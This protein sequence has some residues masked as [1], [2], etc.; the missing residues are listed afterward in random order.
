MSTVPSP[1]EEDR[2]GGIN[3]Q[4]GTGSLRAC[5]TTGAPLPTNCATPEHW[6]SVTALVPVSCFDKWPQMHGVSSVL[7]QLWL[8]GGSCCNMASVAVLRSRC[9]HGL[10]L[11]GG[12]LGQSISLPSHLLR[13]VHTPWPTAP[14]TVPE[15][16]VTG[17]IMLAWCC[18]NSSSPPPFPVMSLGPPWSPRLT[19]PL[20]LAIIIPSATPI[21][22]PC[23]NNL[24]AGLR[25][26]AWTHF[27]GHYS[28][29]HV[30]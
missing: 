29:C 23:M 30:T 14:S 25:N 20:R 21:P 26:E 11:S 22:L 4:G 5:H 8:Q 19:C 2:D 15:A 18:S 24:V 16:S 7:W 27:R 1:L 12:S 13:V 17:H 3:R 28:L 6:S 10:L 9:W